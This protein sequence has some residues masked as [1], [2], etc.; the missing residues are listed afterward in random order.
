MGGGWSAAERERQRERDP[1]PPGSPTTSESGSA[2]EDTQSEE[3]EALA[4]PRVAAVLDGEREY[5][6]T[7]R[8]L[9]CRPC[10]QQVVRLAPDER[11]D[12]VVLRQRVDDEQRTQVMARCPRCRQRYVP[13]LVG[14]RWRLDRLS[15]LPPV[16]VEDPSAAVPPKRPVQRV[17]ARGAPAHSAAVHPAPQ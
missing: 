11:V 16:R 10:G 3:E 14:G 13:Q 4:E 2:T 9:T 8:V 12:V 6:F 7:D 5:R 1:T 15:A 17:R